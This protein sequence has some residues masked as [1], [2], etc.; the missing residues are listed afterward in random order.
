MNKLKENMKD[1]IQTLLI[2]IVILA[3]KFFVVDN[4]RVEGKSMYP[5]LNEGNH[6]DR[7]VIERFKHYTKDYKRRDIIILKAHNLDKDILIKRIIGLPKD[8]VEI[9]SGKV[10]VN[11]EVLKEDYLPEGVIT[12]PNMK[13]V[14]PEGDVFVLGD[15]RGNSTDSR[16]IGPVKFDDILGKATY[17][18][19]LSEF[20]FEKLK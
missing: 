7:V 11:G 1:I 15:N 14:V 10:Y 2:L 6:N 4:A 17:R 12:N 20:S 18:F 5:T 16:I 19:N 9:K 3:V 13:I 8:T